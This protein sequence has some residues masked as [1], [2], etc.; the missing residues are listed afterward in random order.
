MQRTHLALIAVLALAS[1]PALAAVRNVTDPNL[2]RALPSDG[3]VSVSWTDPAQFSDIRNSTNRWEAQRGNWVYDLAAYMRKEATKDLQPGQTLDVRFTD[4]DRAGEYE[5]WHGPSADHIR[6][7]KDI[8]P[9]RMTF[10]YTLRDADGRVV[11]EG[12]RKLTDMSYLMGARPMD[13][14]PLRFEKRMIDDWTHRELNKRALSS[15]P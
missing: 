10:D 12:Q 5:P 4:M 9:P 8:Y 2:P 7:M 11:D 13:S 14:D 1:A 6:I 3:P 15:N